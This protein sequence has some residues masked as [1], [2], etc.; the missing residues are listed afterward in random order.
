M[1]LWSGVL[2]RPGVTRSA[3]IL[4][5]GVATEVT[6]PTDSADQDVGPLQDYL[7]EPDG[8][9][10]RARLIGDVARHY[11]ATMIDSTI[12]YMTS[13]HPV[14]SPLVQC[15]Q[16]L[17][18][19]PYSPKNV[20]ALVAG[21]RVGTLEIKK[22]G[23]DVDPAALRETLPLSGSQTATLILTRVQGRKTAILANRVP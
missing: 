14:S 2:A 5:D 4:R 8:S 21:A 6:G 17:D 3:L 19:I 20:R 23:I 12:A 13:S 9:I 10:I 16:V 22:R 18:T 7:L 11:S 15:F 1:V